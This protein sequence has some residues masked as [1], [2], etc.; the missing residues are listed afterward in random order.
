MAKLTLR[1]DLVGPGK[2]WLLEAVD[3]AGSISATGRTMKTSYR[4]AWLLIDE[5][6]HIFKRRS[7]P[8]GSVGRLAAVPN[9]RRSAGAWCDTIARWKRRRM[10]RRRPI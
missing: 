5:L 7:L 3:E 2:I 9:S 8:L 1:I 6:N 4:R 10:P